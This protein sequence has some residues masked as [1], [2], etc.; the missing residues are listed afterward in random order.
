MPTSSP[1]SMPSP[2]RV[3]VGRWCTRRS[4]GLTTAPSRNARRRTRNM[5]AN[6]VTVTTASTIP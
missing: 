5:D 2:P 3:G 1:I 4:S 6:V